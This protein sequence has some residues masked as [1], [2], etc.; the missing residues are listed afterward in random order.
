M[1]NTVIRRSK[2]IEV[3]APVC[4][5]DTMQARL[6]QC[7]GDWKPDGERKRVNV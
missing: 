4:M 1:Y 7:C 6:F 2:E 5:G 3:A